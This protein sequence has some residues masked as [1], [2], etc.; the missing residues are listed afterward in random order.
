MIKWRFLLTI[1]LLLTVCGY[2]HAKP[3]GQNQDIY[4]YH[5]YRTSDRINIDGRLNEKSWETASLARPFWWPALGQEAIRQTYAKML[6]DDQFLYIGAWLVDKDIYGFHTEHDSRT[7]EDDVFEVFIKPRDDSPRYYEFHVTPLNTT[8][9]ML[10]AR[11][12]ATGQLR[13]WSVFESGMITA[14]NLKG[15]LNNWEDKDQG[16]SVEIA[17]PL[18]AFKDTISLPR[19]GDK[20]KFALCRYDYCV[21]L[22]KGREL[23]SSARLSAVNFHL[24]EDYD[25]L[26]FSS[27]AP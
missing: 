3:G 7:W 10:I 2:A 13:R 23:S 8:L 4:V 12:G 5:V 26:L 6:W 27:Y 24:F 25:I 15:T 19:E 18:I 11:R 22:E 17:I 9:D 20:W 21:H 14:V 16:W 1:C